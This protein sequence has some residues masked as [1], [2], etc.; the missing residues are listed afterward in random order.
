LGKESAMVDIFLRHQRLIM[1]QFLVFAVL[2]GSVVII[3]AIVYSRTTTQSLMEVP[4]HKK[5]LSKSLEKA[6]Q[7]AQRKA[8]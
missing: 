1:I 7:K 8:K 6:F 4:E 5:N 2:F 3:G